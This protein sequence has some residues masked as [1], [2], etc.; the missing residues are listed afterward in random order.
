MDDDE[1]LGYM[2]L[3]LYLQIL[4][5]IVWILLIMKNLHWSRENRQKGL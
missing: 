2:I 3:F 4:Y 1:N 5:I